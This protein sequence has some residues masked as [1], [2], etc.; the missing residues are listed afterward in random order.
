MTIQQSLRFAGLLLGVVLLLTPAYAVDI[1]YSTTGTFSNCGAGYTC[2]GNVLT[3]PS[4]G[5]SITFNGQAAD[6]PNI[7]NVPPPAPIG[8]GFFK[9]TGGAAANAAPDTVSAT[10]TLSITQ[11]DPVFGA[12]T[13]TLT[14]SA[15]GLI[16]KSFS[17]VHV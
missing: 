6:T 11:V 15:A 17:S 2:V 1:S 8:F 14:S 13:E 10:F 9:V 12:G 5:L 7:D 4:T 16:K 3:H